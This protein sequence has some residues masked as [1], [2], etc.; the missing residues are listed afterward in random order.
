M[1]V[2]AVANQKGGC[3]KTTSAV[4]LAGCLAFLGK[5]I[6]LVD[7]DSQGHAGLGLGITPEALDYTLYDALSPTVD[8]RPS[9][10]EIVVKLTQNLHLLPSD[11]TLAAL[12]QELAG[13]S[14]RETRLSD[15]FEEIGEA[16]DYVFLDCAPGLGILMFNALYLADEV[17]I[18]VEPSLFSL[19]GL[20]CFLET[21]RVAEESFAKDFLIHAL[22]TNFDART[23]SSR[24]F[25][26]ELREF[27][28]GTALS[29]TVR[30]N[31]RL[32]EAATAG[33]PIS[34][35][36]KNSTGFHDYMATAAELIERTAER[37]PMAS[38]SWAMGTA[39][40]LDSAGVHST[41]ELAG[42]PPGERPGEEE[43]AL[44]AATAA[45]EQTDTTWE[46]SGEAI[47]KQDVLE[48]EIS[49][50]LPPEPPPQEERE[51]ETVPAPILT[52]PVEAPEVEEPALAVTPSATA[53]DASNKAPSRHH[54]HELM[55][56]EG[57]AKVE[58]VS[59]V[60]PSR[61]K[62]ERPDV[63]SPLVGAKFES[64]RA[65]SSS[66]PIELQ[67]KGPVQ[68]EG[69]TLFMVAAEVGDTVEL[70]GEFNAWQPEL[71]RP[72]KNREGLWRTIKQL[73]TGEY[74][75]KFIVNGEW[76]NDPHNEVTR[77]NPFGGT[78]SVIQISR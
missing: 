69:G 43:P 71:L 32:N 13:L 55:Q 53:A 3:G 70:A 51:P 15:A 42:E 29:S 75:Y 49:A 78:D 35:F 73:K 12:E 17:L 8:P 22:I 37:M 68:L 64:G 50:P 58:E 28:S 39:T 67:L 23:R 31:V 44:A 33:K 2:V 30:R 63:P 38:E 65:G 54:L 24:H 27:L 66:E 4:N 14:G 62:V 52:P 7:L 9:L 46:D 72:V 25:L 16:Y 26:S 77:P 5:R 59:F 10:P 1:R 61:R 45:T 76:L 18:P 21:I 41:V 57:A 11:V 48:T 47:T 19:H 40:P 60:M 20:G 6:L 56:S 36:D 74:R 34:E